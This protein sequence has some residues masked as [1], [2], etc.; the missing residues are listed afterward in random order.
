M[1]KAIETVITTSTFQEVI[2]ERFVP[3]LKG[4]EVTRPLFNFII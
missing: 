3:S 2:A 1:D 4:A